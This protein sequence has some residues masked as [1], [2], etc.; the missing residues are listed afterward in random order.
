MCELLQPVGRSKSQRSCCPHIP[1]QRYVHW[2]STVNRR[3][4]T[5][6]WTHSS[7]GNIYCA[8]RNRP[9]IPGEERVKR[10]C[11]ECPV[12]YVPLVT[13]LT[14]RLSGS[15]DR[16]P[17]I[18]MQKCKF[19]D[20]DGH[21]DSAAAV[22]SPE[23]PEYRTIQDGFS[24]HRRVKW[25]IGVKRSSSVLTRIGF[26]FCFLICSLCLMFECGRG[27]YCDCRGVSEEICDRDDH[28]LFA[29]VVESREKGFCLHNI[30]DSR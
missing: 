5:C 13:S 20:T 30:N 25:V 16:S 8:T 22:D 14:V 27:C 4:N 18:T 11:R 10:S 9:Q 21:R 3:V 26:F 29:D 28:V 17:G 7:S 23:V 6:R 15:G 1:T 2:S 19:P 12:T 24:G